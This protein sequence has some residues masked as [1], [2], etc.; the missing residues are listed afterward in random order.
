MYR[1]MNKFRQQTSDYCASDPFSIA[2]LRLP[3][4]VAAISASAIIKV[5]VLLFVETIDKQQ[6]TAC[7]SS[8]CL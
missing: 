4:L 2:F 1:W 7:S 6:P 5:L 8:R 3:A